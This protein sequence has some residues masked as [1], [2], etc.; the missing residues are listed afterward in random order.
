MT[1]LEQKIKQ[2]EVERARRYPLLDI[3]DNR[4]EIRLIAEETQKYMIELNPDVKRIKIWEAIPRMVIE[5]IRASF[6]KLSRADAVKDGE[7]SVVLGDL[8][9]LGI[10]YMATSDG[11]KF[12]NITPIVRCRSEF[13]WE[14]ISLPYRDEVPVDI[15]NDMADEKCEGLPIQF[16]DTRE[17]IKEISILAKKELENYG[18]IFGDNDWWVL[19]LVFMAFFR[20]TRDWLA[21]HKD[22]GEIGV[23]INFA[24]LLKIAI[25]KEGGMEEDDP[26]DYI[27]SITPNQIFKKENAK[28]DEITESA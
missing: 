5:F 8:M 9:E 7:S 28:S 13:K 22:D 4:R 6:T 12:G 2:S 24:D 26:V 23:E 14:N 3:S 21:E 11:D 18:I 1:E 10:Q 17:E 25:T 27:L 15:A 20:K 19:P 16:F